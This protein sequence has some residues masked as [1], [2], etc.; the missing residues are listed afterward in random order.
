M[1]PS[2]NT[3]RFGPP[4]IRPPRTFPESSADNG[5]QHY[6]G[7][8]SPNPIK[9]P[10]NAGQAAEPSEGTS[11]DL[12]SND[13]TLA[14]RSTAADTSSSQTNSERSEAPDSRKND[15]KS[16]ASPP[17]VPI[18]EPPVPAE[19]VAQDTV[20]PS[21]ADTAQ[22]PATR[23]AEETPGRSALPDGTPPDEPMDIVNNVEDD[24]TDGRPTAPHD[25]PAKPEQQPKR[26]PIVKMATIEPAK[27]IDVAAG[28]AESGEQT[29]SDRVKRRA[30]SGKPSESQVIRPNSPDQVAEHSARAERTAALVAAEGESE[31]SRSATDRS[32]DKHL[33]AAKL[34]ETESGARA[35]PA[36]G[37]LS[38]RLFSRSSQKTEEQHSLTPAE[39]TRFVRRVARGMQTAA[40]QNG[41]IHLRLRPSELGS[42]RL[43]VTIDRGTLSA[44][45]QTETHMARTALLDALPQ[46]R[47]RLTEQGIRIE[48][49]HVSVGGQGGGEL[50]QQSRHGQLDTVPHSGPQRPRLEEKQTVAAA[51]TNSLT[52]APGKLNVIV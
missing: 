44:R 17:A 3:R 23:L 46:L 14:N 35:E 33:A 30:H 28:K 27:P 52:V 24:T 36:R 26:V 19:G 21:Q 31:P 10:T 38:N 29:K 41:P 12:P 48:Q 42:L 51:S 9:P 47:D 2:S 32:A 45:I 22:Q 40:D 5:F 50:P 34:S 16:T 7:P 37:E 13:E 43:E 1:E 6:L 15:D 20:T 4:D 49:F 11:S 8:P 25:T 18:D 39:Q